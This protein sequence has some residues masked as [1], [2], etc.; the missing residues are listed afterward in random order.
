[1][2]KS[3]AYLLYEQIGVE[4]VEGIFL[5]EL[6]MLQ[7]TS[8]TLLELNFKK[9]G[10]FYTPRICE[11]WHFLGTSYVN[12]SHPVGANSKKVIQSNEFPPLR[13]AGL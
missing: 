13:N 6:T 10:K 5:M 2:A 1:M 11:K 7:N 12:K 9:F 3:A 8:H 4:N